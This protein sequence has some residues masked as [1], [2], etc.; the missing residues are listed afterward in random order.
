[1]K[2]LKLP[3]F[4]EDKL[5]FFKKEKDKITNNLFK[6]LSIEC[7]KCPSCDEMSFHDWV[8]ENCWYWKEV[9]IKNKEMQ[10]YNKREEIKEK[11]K[12]VDITKVLN[13]DNNETHKKDFFRRLD[14]KDTCK[15]WF[16]LF[17][18]FF[19]IEIVNWWVDT[20][21]VSW[22]TFK[23]SNWKFV[24]VVKQKWF[25][26][27]NAYKYKRLFLKWIW[28]NKKKINQKNNNSKN[29]S[30]YIKPHPYF[31]DFLWK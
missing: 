29:K 14:I 11:T 7:D 30:N 25:L 18:E 19:S 9:E 2:Q 8:C 22:L 15:M 4:E 16:I 27:W 13:F 3:W 1:M 10:I 28:E 17:W 5:D 12:E 23:Y 20:I 24:V 26:R 31:D 6:N 21:E